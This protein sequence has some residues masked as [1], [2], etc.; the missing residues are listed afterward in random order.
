MTCK[1]E[2]FNDEQFTSVYIKNDDNI[3]LYMLVNKLLCAAK[4]QS[5][6]SQNRIRNAKKNAK[7]Y[8]RKC[9]IKSLVTSTFGNPDVIHSFNPVDVTGITLK[10]QGVNKVH[11]LNSNDNNKTF[12]YSH[13]NCSAISEIISYTIE[14]L[15]EIKLDAFPSTTDPECKANNVAANNSEHTFTEQNRK[16]LSTK[17]LINFKECGEQ[18]SVQET[19]KKKTTSSCEQVN[20]AMTTKCLQPS[21]IYDFI[22]RNEIRAHER[23]LLQNPKIRWPSADTI[24]KNNSPRKL[25]DSLINQVRS[26]DRCKSVKIEPKSANHSK[27]TQHYRLRLEQRCTNHTKDLNNKSVGNIRQQYGKYTNENN[28]LESKKLQKS[29]QSFKININNV[30]NTISNQTINGQPCQLNRYH[31]FLNRKLSHKSDIPHKSLS[32]GFTDNNKPRIL[33]LHTSAH[34]ISKQSKPKSTYNDTLSHKTSVRILSEGISTNILEGDIKQIKEPRTKL[35]NHSSSKV[36]NTNR[37]PNKENTKRKI[38]HNFKRNSTNLRRLKICWN[39]SKHIYPVA[40]NINKKTI[41]D[42]CLS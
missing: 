7:D 17:E 22:H 12:A 20:R 39:K 21:Y 2:E 18:G 29:V 1:I 38:N 27:G 10:P 34:P 30:S 8:T 16:L 3:S 9:R 6:I 37:F 35:K 31:K 26:D 13:D 24:L 23:L 4:Q 25:C 14:K 36:L 28:P 32:I 40:Q 19:I 42:M 33:K 5:N 41:V 15:S 11:S